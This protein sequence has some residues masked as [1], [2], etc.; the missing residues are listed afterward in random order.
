MSIP[1]TVIIGIET[2]MMKRYLI[3]PVFF[4]FLT[5]QVN[6][7]LEAAE[8]GKQA[9]GVNAIINVGDPQPPQYYVES[10]IV[11]GNDHTDTAIIKRYILIRPGDP[12][13]DNRV[14]ESRFRLLSTGWFSEVKAQ[15]RKGTERGKI[16]VVF[17]VHE[18]SSIL[19]DEVHIG[20]SD[21]S[22]FW[23]G[24]SV[25]ETNFVGKGFALTLGVLGG[26]GF[27]ALRG[28]FMDPDL[29][30]SEF[31]LGGGLFYN[32]ARE[33]TVDSQTNQLFTIVDYRRVGGDIIFG[34]RLDNYFHFYMN[35]HFEVVDATFRDKTYPPLV[36]VNNGYSRVSDLTFS[37][38]RDTRNDL[39]LPSSGWMFNFSVK[40][41]SQ[42]L[43]SSYDYSKYTLNV[44]VVLPTVK[45]HSWK[46]RGFGGLI[47]GDAPFFDQYFLGDYF[48]FVI[49]KPTLPRV[50]EINV[51]SI[52]NYKTLA[53]SAG[54]DYAITI[55]SGGKKFYRGFVY[56]AVLASGTSTV[57]E[58]I[59]GKG[60]S[61]D[62]IT[63]V[64]FDIGLKM[65][66]SVGVF[67]F[68]LA[69]WT[70]LLLLLR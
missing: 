51:T 29:A 50:W 31:K 2:P 39:W 6:G 53:Y 54:M 13:N 40:L 66:T 69:Y 47:Q 38:I 18:R 3:I 45:G 57:D 48:Y 26:D 67:T 8:L 46:I 24:A 28:K 49:D 10:I 35:Y 17:S 68:S 43:G 20:F 16:Q 15:I 33:R 27:L 9:P 22:H 7:R 41:S 32:D 21:V 58:I 25:T 59:K 36:F 55:F 64:S 60:K 37:V 70:N 30:G 56:A 11:E 5:L 23:A 61:G 14:E 44:E 63:P 42:I 52:I 4:S 1:F 34:R 12:L 19:I 65:D 62:S